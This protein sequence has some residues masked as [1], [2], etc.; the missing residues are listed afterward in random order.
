MT[1]I[2]R[3]SLRIPA[4]TMK[5]A[6]EAAAADGVSVNAFMAAA[7]AEKAAALKAD[8]YFRQR[9][10]GLTRQDALDLLAKTGRPGR[11]RPGD[12]VD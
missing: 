7:I 10:E 9:A 6:E 2:K 11:V 8:D 5:L 1:D 4:S 12:E 3:K